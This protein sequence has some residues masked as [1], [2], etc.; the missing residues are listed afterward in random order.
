[1]PPTPIWCGP[2]FLLQGTAGVS[3]PPDP[4]FKASL[5]GAAVMA[6]AARFLLVAMMPSGTFAALPGNAFAVTVRHCI[7]VFY[8]WVIFAPA[9]DAT[10][11]P[12]FLA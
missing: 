9:V 4:A 1:M 5:A 2:A 10:P 7:Y 8:K 6:A 3:A 11:L 12:F